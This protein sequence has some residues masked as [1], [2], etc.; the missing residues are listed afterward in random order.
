[1][2]FINRSIRDM[3]YKERKNEEALQNTMENSYGLDIEKDTATIVLQMYKARDPPKLVRAV[4]AL[5]WNET[6]ESNDELFN[7]MSE[8]D[9]LIEDG[10]APRDAK[11]SE[12]SRKK[13]REDIYVPSL[14]EMAE[15]GDIYMAK[16]LTSEVKVMLA[17]ELNP[18]NQIVVVDDYDHWEDLLGW[19]KLK[20]LPSGKNKVKETYGDQISN[21]MFDKMFPNVPKSSSSKSRSSGRKPKKSN[22]ERELNVALGSSQRKRDTIKA[23]DIKSMFENKGKIS[24]WGLTADRL[25]LFPSD[26]ERNMTDY[27]WIT[28]NHGYEKVAIANCTKGVY[29]YLSHL[30]QVYHIDKY[31]HDSQDVVIDTNKGPKRLG[32]I[33]LNNHVLI[34]IHEDNAEW[35]ESGGVVDNIPDILEDHVNSYE[36]RRSYRVDLPDPEDMVLSITTPSEMFEA[37]PF[38]RANVTKRYRVAD[39]DG[40]N[41]GPTVLYGDASTKLGHRSI[42]IKDDAALY[43]SARLSEWDTDSAVVQSLYHIAGRTGES[44]EFMSLLETV[45]VLHDMG[46]PPKSYDGGGV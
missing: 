30:P 44:N 23:S 34:I 46:L 17:R 40:N 22:G 4:R 24:S 13:A 39:N 2:D 20:S 7:K 25:V 10:L 21:D 28:G 18:E 41:D 37:V 12:V 8:I 33:D 32:D 42:Y 27:C 9:T 43:V 19:K 6:A 29:E 5:G 26:T 45:A 11:A 38:Y 16:T 15:G 3:G 14:I 1:M 36:S 31:M 35:Y